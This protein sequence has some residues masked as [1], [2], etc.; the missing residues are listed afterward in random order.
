MLPPE[1]PTPVQ[2]SL[3]QPCPMTLPI[4]PNDSGPA[5]LLTWQRAARQYHRCRELQAS[6]AKAVAIHEAEVLKRYC[7]ALAQLG[8]SATDCGAE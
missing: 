1:P 2:Q 4:P 3:R 8:Q 6:L 5:V 7:T